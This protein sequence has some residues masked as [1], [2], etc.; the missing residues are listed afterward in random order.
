MATPRLA[1][2]WAL[3][4]SADGARPASISAPSEICVEMAEICARPACRARDQVGWT[5]RSRPGCRVAAC[6]RI[7][8]CGVEHSPTVAAPRSC[9]CAWLPLFR[10][11]LVAPCS[12]STCKAVCQ[13]PSFASRRLRPSS[14]HAGPAAATPATAG[15]ARQRDYTVGVPL[16]VHKAYIYGVSLLSDRKI[17][18]AV[19]LHGHG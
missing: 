13:L 12:S 6:T 7:P 14:Y 16:N 3:G 8:H 2:S 18:K 5:L 11:L 17:A 4:G 19:L 9:G 15:A 1:R 10:A